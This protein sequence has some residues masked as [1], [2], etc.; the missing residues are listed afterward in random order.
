MKQPLPSGVR[1]L[2]FEDMPPEIRQ[3]E[4]S[5]L[6][7]EL[8]QEREWIAKAESDQYPNKSSVLGG[9]ALVKLVEVPSGVNLPFRQ[10]FRDRT[11]MSHLRE[12]DEDQFSVP[13][14]TPSTLAVLS[15]VSENARQIFES[16][17]SGQRYMS[18]NDIYT[19]QFSVVSMT[20]TVNYQSTLLRRGALALDGDSAH[21]YGIAF[22]VDHSGFYVRRKNG[23]IIS[24]NGQNNTGLYSDE[25][26]RAFDTS[27][28]EAERRDEVT[29][30]TELPQGR[31]CWH[32]TA[33]PLIN[34][35]V[36]NE[37]VLVASSGP[38][39]R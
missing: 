19:V 9:I 12:L 26:I 6:P 28:K 34:R 35:A 27:L 5:R 24:V 31:G 38:M 25:P 29:Y 8:V 2:R 4:M 36:D 37:S 20:R 7:N 21:T 14:L 23:E 22:D 11:S 10:Y 18:E 13:F 17:P 1:V 33:N 32:V 3:Q 39:L 15:S 30:I 16:S